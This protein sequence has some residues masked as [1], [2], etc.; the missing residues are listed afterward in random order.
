MD[1]VIPAIGV[2]TLVIV[3]ILLI[4]TVGRL[5]RKVGPNQ[6]L[7]VYG[8]GG[9]RVIT[10]GSHFVIPLYQRAQEFPLELMSFD[11]APPQDL[12]T[13]QGVAV[14][15]EAVTQIKVRSDEQSIRTAAE[16]FLSKR[17]DEREN[18]IRLVMEGH[19]R[20]IVGQL[21]VEELVKDP[22][23]VGS[24]MLKTVTPDMEKMGLEVISFTIKDVRDKNDYISNMGRP[25]IVEIRKQA[26][27][28]SALAQRDTQIQQANAS[29]EAAVAKSAADQGRV[30]AETESLAMQAESQRNLSLKKAA[31][32]AEVKKQQATADKTYDIQANL[33]QQQVVTEAVKVTEAEKNAQ[34]KVQ[35]AEIKRRELELQ[36]TIQK[37]AEA[38]R[39]R[40]ETVAERSEEHTS[41]L[42]SQSNLVCRLLLEKK[43]KNKKKKKKTK[44]NKQNTQSNQ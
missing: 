28:A 37:A 44:R 10:G 21:T 2:V 32:D 34:I 35:E 5:L 12:Y 39:R 24:K 3:V 8:A 41:E 40:I 19:L 22:E 16:Q 23:N 11:V 42:Q 25:Q 18:L 43:K 6:A 26:D 9:T 15:V 31:F 27:I 33:M 4:Q 14:N 7:I 36:A 13:S 30:K 1:L 20:G 29:R 38:D 17:Q